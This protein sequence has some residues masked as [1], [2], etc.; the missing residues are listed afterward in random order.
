MAAAV[1]RDDDVDALEGAVV[2]RGK[3]CC[4]KGI[5]GMRR[6]CAAASLRCWPCDAVAKCLKQVDG[7]LLRAGRIATA[8]AATKQ[9]DAAP[10]GGR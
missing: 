2:L 5:T 7:R 10:S 6:L 8:D 9:S 4:S 1:Q 3:S